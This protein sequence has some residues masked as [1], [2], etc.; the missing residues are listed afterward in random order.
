MA[1]RYNA[2]MFVKKSFKFWLK[3]TKSQKAALQ[4]VLDECRFLY[5]LCLE[6]RIL[7]YEELDMTLTKYDQLMMLP[8]LKEKAFFL[9]RRSFA[10]STGYCQ[11]A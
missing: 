10:S 3:L 4:C 1:K 5:N 2:S 7:A 9:T 11:S 8:F 6:Q